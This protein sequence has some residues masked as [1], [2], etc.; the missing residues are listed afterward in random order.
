M[1]KRDN[2]FSRWLLKKLIIFLKIY[3]RWYR[4]WSDPVVGTVWGD[5]K[6]VK[7]RFSGKMLP[8][9]YLNNFFKILNRLS[10][11][12]NWR[13]KNWI[14]LITLDN[15]LFITPGT[16]QT[17]VWTPAKAWTKLPTYLLT[18]GYWQRMSS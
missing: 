2:G 17:K 8:L 13:N 6:E 14:N 15:L 7:N 10:F 16:V 11:L 5:E 12:I 3:R 18:Y 9:L 4:N 1:L